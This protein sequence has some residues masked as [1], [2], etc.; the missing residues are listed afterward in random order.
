MKV[1][2]ADLIDGATGKLHCLVYVASPETLAE[3]LA[4][5]LVPENITE[6]ALSPALMEAIRAEV[7]FKVDLAGSDRLQ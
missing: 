5:R 3:W 4:A 1:Y 6:V 2:R 7:E